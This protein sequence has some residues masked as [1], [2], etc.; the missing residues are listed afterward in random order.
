[1]PVRIKRVYDARAKED[2]ERILVDRLWPRGLWKEKAHLDEWMKD[3]AP[4]P[5]LRQWFGHKSER[6]EEFQ[7]RYRQGAGA[8]VMAAFKAHV[9]DAVG[10]H[11]ARCPAKVALFDFMNANALTTEPMA[12]GRSPDYVDLVH[13]RPPAGLRLLAAMGLKAR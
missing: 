12:G 10:R 9:R 13:F 8:D 1:M 6:W 4:T 2:G 3:I 11:N 7:A 5:A